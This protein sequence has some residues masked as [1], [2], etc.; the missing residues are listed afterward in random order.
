MNGDKRRIFFTFLETTAMLPQHKEAFFGVANQLKCWI[1]LRE[2]NELSDRWIGR[3]GYT[4][5]SVHCKAKTADNRFH[6]WAGLVV[7]P[8]VCTDAFHHSTL[9]DAIDK[10]QKFT[11]GNRL[12]GGFTCDE[13]G[14]EKGLVKSRGAAIHADFDLMVV[15]KADS[16]GAMAYTS[17]EEQTELS[18]QVGKLLNQRFGSPMIQHGSEFSWTGGVGARESENVLFFGPNR[19][20]QL[21]KSSMPKKAVAH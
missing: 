7:N 15:C 11:D 14:S 1:G 18:E 17:P 13:S 4:P 19:R 16:S 8:N 9:A 21:G 2:P 6:P 20:F 5:K 12:P 3:P 10:W